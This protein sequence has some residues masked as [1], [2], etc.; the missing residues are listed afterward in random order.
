VFKIAIDLAAEMD[1][2]AEHQ[3]AFDL[4]RTARA[5]LRNGSIASGR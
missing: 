4:H 2:L 1:H 3:R 5:M